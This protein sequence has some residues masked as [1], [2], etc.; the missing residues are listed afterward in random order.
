VAG[1]EGQ[2][3]GLAAAAAAA[4]GQGKGTAFGLTP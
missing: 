1:L 4:A 3:Q 2:V